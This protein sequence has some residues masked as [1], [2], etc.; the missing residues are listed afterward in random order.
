MLGLARSPTLEPAFD[1]ILDPHEIAQW[2]RD[3]GSISLG[4]AHR[5]EQRIIAWA[6]GQKA[7][8]RKDGIAEALGRAQAVV[9]RIMSAAQRT[10]ADKSG[11]SRSS[12]P[13]GRT[14][15]KEHT[16]EAIP[17]T[18]PMSA[19][20]RGQSNRKTTNQR[21]PPRSAYGLRHLSG[22]PRPV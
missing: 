16:R 8:G 5:L 12:Y 3:A 6:E 10:A 21:S 17:P 15:P 4:G 1:D 7:Q 11:R 18:P 14:Q 20:S 2:L 19:R 22:L 13:R 9:A